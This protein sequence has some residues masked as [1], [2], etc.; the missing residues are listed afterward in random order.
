MISLEGF[1]WMMLL[2]VHVHVGSYQGSKD[3][4]WILRVLRSVAVI[5][6]CS[7]RYMLSTEDIKNTVLKLVAFLFTLFTVSKATANK[8]NKKAN[9]TVDTC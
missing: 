7:C 8:V 9:N 4:I 5:L 3:V 6:V 2:H 1:T